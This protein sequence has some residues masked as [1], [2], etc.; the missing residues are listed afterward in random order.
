MINIDNCSNKNLAYNNL[1]KKIGNNYYKN[2][3]L[4]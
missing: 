4:I 1:L 2:I 3:K